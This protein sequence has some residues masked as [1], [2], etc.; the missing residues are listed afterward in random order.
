M[1]D[2]KYKKIICAL[3]DMNHMTFVLSTDMRQN[4]LDKINEYENRYNRIRCTF[5]HIDKENL[6]TYFT[7]FSTR[8]SGAM[9]LV[10]KRTSTLENNLSQI[11]II[12]SK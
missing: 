5:K 12:R 1:I 11:A 7:D 4:I 3:M 9:E 2:I 6:G 10:R 8:F